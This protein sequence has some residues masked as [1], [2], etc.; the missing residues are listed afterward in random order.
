MH[1]KRWSHKGVGGV[2]R[3]EKVKIPGQRTG[4]YRGTV[5]S[6]IVATLHE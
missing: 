5:N 1:D 2:R 6:L 3:Q 4:D